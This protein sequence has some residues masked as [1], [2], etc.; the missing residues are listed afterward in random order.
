MSKSKGNTVAPAK[1]LES[2]GADALR[3]FHLFTGPPADDVDWSDQ[4]DSVIDGC[5][6]FLDRVWRLAVPSDAAATAAAAGGRGPNREP[7]TTGADGDL[8]IRRATHR[9]IDRVD[10]DYER[11]SFNT[12]VAACM[13]FVNEL[14]AHLREGM[15]SQS[16]FDEAVEHGVRRHASDNAQRM[17]QDCI[18]ASTT[19]YTSYYCQIF[20]EGISPRRAT[21][22]ATS[23]LST[24]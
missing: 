6:R 13:E 12:A 5:G 19:P 23:G 22:A 24:T 21:A 20:R 10:R 16:A 4:T 11:W 14:S 2:V 17:R 15:A 8:D 3:L 7:Q 9:L 1:Y 18:F